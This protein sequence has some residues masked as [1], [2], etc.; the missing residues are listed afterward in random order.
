MAISEL[1][2]SEET[3]VVG[4]V[5]VMVVGCQYSNKQLDFYMRD[6]QN[7]HDYATVHL[8]I[9]IARKPAMLI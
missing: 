4:Y 2:S 8:L 7:A 1:V 9:N 6:G 5:A 3:Y